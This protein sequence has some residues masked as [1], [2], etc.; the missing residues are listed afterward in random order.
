MFTLKLTANVVVHGA[1]DIEAETV[2]DAIA[3]LQATAELNGWESD[4]WQRGHFQ[5]DWSSAS[6]LTVPAHT[7]PDGSITDEIV[8]LE[9]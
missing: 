4:A 1:V 7:R 9:E 6:H 8:L 5:V 3:K 2:D